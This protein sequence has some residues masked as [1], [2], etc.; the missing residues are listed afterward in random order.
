MSGQT[1]D[2]SIVICTR[3]RPADLDRAIASIRTSDSRGLEAEIIVV[4][5]GD[6]PRSIP[7]VRYVHLPREGRG[8][9]YARNAG[10]REAR[11]SVILF[12]DDDCEV[13]PG[14][15]DALNE[16]F[17]RDPKILGV[18][19]AVL[20]RNCGPIGYAENILG[21]P[22]GG[23]RYLR[24]SAGQV[25]PTS[26][27]STCNCAYRRDAILQVGGF[28]ESARLGAEDSLLAERISLLGPC[29]YAPTAVVYHR[30]R[31]SLPAVFRWFVR[32]GQSEIGFRSVTPRPRRAAWYLLRS[33]L[34][35]RGLILLAAIGRWPWLA[36][37][38]P[39]G[40]VGYYGLILWRYR[41]ARAYPTH[42]DAWWIVPVVKAVMDCGAEVGRWKSLL[43]SAG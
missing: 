21:F 28:S 8:F 23:L 7:G 13:Q 12:V 25:V 3:D 40:L 16:P 26:F 41:F 27:L 18:A 19:G 39:P 42:R 34:A 37:W 22:G 43:R 4:E 15:I 35:L 29:V 36:A 5:E 1:R 38:I 6:G 10:V 20:V 11:A 2:C 14:W 24:R 17:L 32:R 31:G 9:G 30:A 33:S